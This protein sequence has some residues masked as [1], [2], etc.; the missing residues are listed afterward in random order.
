M[1]GVELL[2]GAVSLGQL[3]AARQRTVVVLGHEGSGIP[4]EAIDCLTGA[5]E[6]PMVGVGTS[7]NVAVAG[8]LVLYRLAGLA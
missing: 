7:L 3:P 1:L 4:A 8:T 5:V 6:I 2:D